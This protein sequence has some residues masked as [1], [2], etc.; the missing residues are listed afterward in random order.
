MTAHCGAATCPGLFRRAAE[1]VDKVLRGAHPAEIPVDLIAAKAL[2]LQIPDK[3][4][5]TAD[6]RRRP[7]LPTS[8]A[9]IHRRCHGAA[10]ASAS[11]S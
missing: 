3:L 5:A 2:A 7:A 10:H 9:S 11:V 4:L 6:Q 1:L 8:P